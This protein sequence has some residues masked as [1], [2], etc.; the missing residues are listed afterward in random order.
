MSTPAVDDV[1][2]RMRSA[3]GFWRRERPLLRP[4][5]WREGAESVEPVKIDWL[6]TWLQQNFGD[7]PRG[8]AM[9]ILCSS[10]LRGLPA[11]TDEVLRLTGWQP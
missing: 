11:L 4:S 3:G 6:D 8:L 1:L 9:E 2:T 7:V 10:D 5:L